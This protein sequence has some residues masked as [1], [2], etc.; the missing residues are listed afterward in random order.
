MTDLELP[1]LSEDRERVPKR[2]PRHDASDYSEQE[3]LISHGTNDSVDEPQGRFENVL[4]IREHTS[5]CLTEPN[6]FPNPVRR[7]FSRDE[8]LRPLHVSLYETF[9]KVRVRRP[10]RRREG[11][12]KRRG[13]AP[14]LSL[15]EEALE[16]SPSSNR[17]DME[18]GMFR[19]Y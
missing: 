16:Q 7:K 2:Q 15:E 5:K 3:Q 12:A 18:T 17:T 9:P 13:A 1:L 19:R 14:Q 4:I 10:R 11:D 8:N 6:P